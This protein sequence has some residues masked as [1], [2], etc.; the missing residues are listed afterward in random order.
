MMADLLRNN[1]VVSLLIHQLIGLSQERIEG[2]AVSEL[3]KGRGKEEREREGGRGR[4]H[5][6]MGCMWIQ[7][8]VTHP[9]IHKLTSCGV[10]GWCG[11]WLT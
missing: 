8:C 4:G 3:G 1:T 6:N 9:Q 2:L 5:E 7:S 10:V 11:G